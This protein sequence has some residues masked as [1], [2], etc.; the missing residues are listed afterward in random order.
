M[1]STFVSKTDD[2]NP[3]V[4]ITQPQGWMGKFKHDIHKVCVS[5][6]TN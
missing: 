5:G 1:T 4:E 6:V 2:A 3:N